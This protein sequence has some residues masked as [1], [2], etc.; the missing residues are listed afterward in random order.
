MRKGLL[1][2][3]MVSLAGK[4]W[5][6]VPERRRDFDERRPNE[7]LI[8][9]AVASLPG[10]GIF[11]GVLSSFSNIAGSGIDAAVAVAESVD[12]T[13]IS[14]RVAALRDVPLPLP[15]MTFDYQYGNIKLGNF[16]TFLPGRDSP[17]FTIPITAEFDFQLIRPTI[18]LFERRFNL[19]YTLSY[20]KGFGFD[21]DGNEFPFSDH[22]ASGALF[23]DFTDDVVD[24]HVGVRLTYETTLAAPKESILGTS[25]NT[26]NIFGDD[27][28]ITVESYE[29]GIFIPQSEQVVWVWNNRYF[30]ATGREESDVV[31]SGGSPPLRGYP[32]GRWR[33]RY[34]VFSAL[35]WRYTTETRVEL[36]FILA[37]GIV[38]GLQYALFYEV[39]QVSP[40]P[41]KLLYEDMHQSYGAGV[42]A[43]FDAIVLRLD[44][45]QSDEG[46]Q[47]HLT[48]GQPF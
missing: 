31:I 13:D 21:E 2:L 15:G 40:T 14:V 19:T 7:Y 42:R 48:I 39:G 12:E 32:D 4:A 22:N 1:V 47:V 33:D 18:R 5:A 3:L 20:F 27:Q 28:E 44:V 8:L 30:Q 26:G 23:L 24:P 41:G 34:G 43:L 46:T 9:P 35:E 6:L 38:Q 11:V 17:N 29:V 37:R 45:A 36:D 25:K 16:Q 10:I